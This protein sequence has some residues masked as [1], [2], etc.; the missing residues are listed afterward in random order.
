MSKPPSFYRVIINWFKHRWGDKRYNNIQNRLER[1]E[2]AYYEEK[3]KLGDLDHTMTC[4]RLYIDQEIKY[5]FDKINDRF[6]ATDA[7]TDSVLTMMENLMLTLK[8]PPRINQNKK[9]AK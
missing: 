4:H 1:L 3:E 5:E 7:A 6:K 8:F 9:R 2:H